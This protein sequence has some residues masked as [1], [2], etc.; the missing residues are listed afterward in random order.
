MNGQMIKREKI[1]GS[2]RISNYIWVVI[3]TLGGLGFFLSGISSY[4]KV[5]LIPFTDST[6]LVFIP[7]G[8]LLTFYGTVALLISTY[9]VLT[10]FWDIGGG[11]NEFNKTDQLIRIVRKGFPGKDRE[12]F[13]VYPLDIVKN[14]AIEIKDGLNPRRMIYLCTTDDRRIPL[15]EVGEP[16]PLA[17]L[18]EKATQLADFLETTVEQD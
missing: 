1:T 14:I 12:I 7:Q 10:I 4:I 5:N 8:I 18:E 11:Y 6:Q 3:L 16:M 2:R 17:L 9:I 13:L 15:T